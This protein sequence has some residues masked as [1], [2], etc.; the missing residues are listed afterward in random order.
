VIIDGELK[1]VFSSK[2]QTLNTVSR[3][4]YKNMIAESSLGTGSIA[5]HGDKLTD[6]Y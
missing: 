2:R 6:P 3:S 4:K 1:T 5:T